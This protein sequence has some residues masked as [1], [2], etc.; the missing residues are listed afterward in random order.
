MRR[1]ALKEFGS[2]DFSN[3]LGVVLLPL[4]G[5][6]HLGFRLGLL[7]LVRLGLD[8]FLDGGKQVRHL[9]SHR[10]FALGSLV[11]LASSLGVVLLAVLNVA[12]GGSGPVTSILACLSRVGVLGA[13]SVASAM[14]SVMIIVIRAF[15]TRKIGPRSR[16]CLM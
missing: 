9:G 4:K 15:A 5:S 10:D 7:V 16:E 14:F 13:L 11:S 2:V 3:N 1:R 6:N 8:G 12:G